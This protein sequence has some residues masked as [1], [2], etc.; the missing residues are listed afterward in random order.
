MAV[1]AATNAAMR[2]SDAGTP[3]AD[4][5]PTVI[6]AGTVSVGAVVS[7]TVTWPAVDDAFPAVS[8]AVHVT[9][10]APTGNV[11]PDAG[12]H[13]TG[14]GP[15]TASTAVGAA[16]VTGAPDGPTAS[17]DTA[18]LPLITGPFLSTTVTVNE[19]DALPSSSPA[20]QVTVVDPSGKVE[21]DAGAHVI[22]SGLPAG[23]VALAS[24]VTTAPSA[25]CASTVR[26][27]GSEKI[28]AAAAPPATTRRTTTAASENRIST[29]ASPARGEEDGDGE[30]DEEREP[31]GD[32]LQPPLGDMDEAAAG[33]ERG[34]DRQGQGDEG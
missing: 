32:Q 5:A 20:V 7:T 15:A 12:A 27:P 3:A 33:D 22:A 2:G 23:F 8:V 31:G 13:V 34:R 19:A 4:A 18:T 1:A 26:S 25:L 10:V 9:A 14:T 11:E 28:G 29:L 24:Y 16:N 6:G 30:A 17:T 21:P